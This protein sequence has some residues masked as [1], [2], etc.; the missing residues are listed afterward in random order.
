MSKTRSFGASATSGMM[1]M[2]ISV[3][4][5]RA[6]LFIMHI[7]LRFILD[8]RDYGIFAVVSIALAF[9]A[10][11]QNAGA[12]KVLIQKQDQYQVLVKDYTDFALYMGL[13]G[14]GVLVAIGLIF[15]KFYRNSELFYVIGLSALAVPFTSLISIQFARFSID[16]RFR[17]MFAIDFYVAVTNAAV[18][19]VSAYLGARFYSIGLGLVVSTI[20]R[21]LLNLRV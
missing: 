7:I 6:L 8:V 2:S 21:Y 19:I 11:L 18:V 3:L 5:S 10:G 17:E 4:S 12:S 16:L 9:V 13:I 15:G 14:A 20:V 1:W